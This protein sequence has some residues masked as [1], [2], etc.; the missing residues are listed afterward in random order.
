M[1][2]Q[3]TLFL[4]DQPTST[5]AKLLSKKTASTY[6]VVIAN[7]W[8]SEPKLELYMSEQDYTRPGGLPVESGK[9]KGARLVNTNSAR[10]GAFW[11]RINYSSATKAGEQ[12][13][14]LGTKDYDEALGWTQA[15]KSV[16]VYNQFNEE[17]MEVQE[18]GQSRVPACGTPRGTARRC[19]ASATP[20]SA[21]STPCAT[22]LSTPRSVSI[23]AGSPTK[24]ATSIGAS[25]ASGQRSSFRN[26]SLTP[27]S[28]RSS[29]AQM[30]AQPAPHE[31][32][33]LP[34]QQS[35]P[36][37]AKLGLR[38]EIADLMR[39]EEVRGA[40]HS[41]LLPS[42]TF[43]S[44]PRVPRSP[45]RAYH[46]SFLSYQSSRITPRSSLPAHHSPLAPLRSA[47]ARATTRARS[48]SS[49]SVRP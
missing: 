31:P 37:I 29:A 6:F 39:R 5:T 22:P 41:L 16:G 14:V 47:P 1:L 38:E 17:L 30:A 11:F 27:P 28:P 33:P 24:T 20:T 21:M 43:Y 42:T 9:L 7:P 40:A 35:A 10:K 25:P 48:G 44:W 3:G 8:E 36:P 26:S 13:H 45:L 46:S 49:W 23:G 15:L 2:R 32:A 4:E 12:K 18:Q 34:S 19:S